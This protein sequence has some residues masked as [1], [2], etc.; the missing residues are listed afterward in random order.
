MHR[1]EGCDDGVG[2]AVVHDID[3]GDL[4]PCSRQGR[5]RLSLSGRIVPARGV[6]LVDVL[7]R[8]A[9]E[10]RVEDRVRAR[11]EEVSVVVGIGPL[12]HDRV[13]GAVVRDVRLVVIFDV[14]ALRHTHSVAVE[15][16]VVVQAVAV[17]QAVVGDDG[18]VLGLGLGDD[19]G[20]RRAIHWG[21]DQDAGA[22]GQHRVGLRRLGS[23]NALGV[24]GVDG[25]ARKIRLD[26][27]L[28]KWMVSRFPPRRRGA[29]GKQEG[30]V[31]AVLAVF[32]SSSGARAAAAAG[33]QEHSCSE[34]RGSYDLEAR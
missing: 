31:L 13:G 17:D 10:E 24:R 9:R 1:L 33:S 11:A 12:D 30:D 28:G 16:L 6:L 15:R 14:L 29:L 7:Q 26:G 4:V 2:H 20:C 25:R 34:E 21:D 23:G 3:D 8:A 32:N 19:G 27:G 18:D 5:R 22:L